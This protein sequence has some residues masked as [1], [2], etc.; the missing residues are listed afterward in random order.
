M[1]TG[2]SFPQTFPPH[3]A[4]YSRIFNTFDYITGTGNIIWRGGQVISANLHQRNLL[5]FIPALLVANRA[6]T[7]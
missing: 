5:S 4:Y 1:F 3:K 6:Q 2:E 7:L